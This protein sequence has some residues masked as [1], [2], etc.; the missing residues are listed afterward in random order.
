LFKIYYI[1]ADRSLAVRLIFAILS[2]CG[3]NFPPFRP[4]LGLR[5]RY[6]ALHAALPLRFP[7]DLYVMYA[8]LRLRCVTMVTTFIWRH[9]SAAA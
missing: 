1:Q 4:H 7:V 8:L 3:L 6:T 9:S 2:A 5:L